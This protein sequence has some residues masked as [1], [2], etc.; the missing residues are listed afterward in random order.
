MLKPVLSVLAL[1]ASAAHAQPDF[2]KVVLTGDMLELRQETFTVG[3]VQSSWV[4][5]A[6]DVLA[7]LRFVNSENPVVTPE[8][9]EALVLF[10]AGGEP[11]MLLRRRDV[12]AGLPADAFV[13]ELVG[14]AAFGA[15]GSF[16]TVARLAGPTISRGTNDEALLYIEPDGRTTV[17]LNSGQ[18]VPGLPEG[19]RF[20]QNLPAPSLGA[21]GEVYFSAV[22]EN[23]DMLDDRPFLV[24]RRAPGGQVERQALMGSPVPGMP[25]GVVFASD[26]GSRV[27]NA[28]GD[29]LFYALFSG[30]EIPADDPVLGLFG[31]RDGATR[32]IYGFDEPIPG[33]DPSVS[34]TR[35]IETRINSQGRAAVIFATDA[36]R[37][38]PG[39]Y[40][41]DVV[42]A[43][44]ADGDLRPIART[45][46]PSPEFGSGARF[47]DFRSLSFNG[48]G[49]VAF[50]GRLFGSGTFEFF[51]DEVAYAERNGLLGLVARETD[52]AP[53]DPVNRGLARFEIAL[54]EEGRVLLPADLKVSPN[55]PNGEGIFFQNPGAGVETIAV[56]NQQILADPGGAF[57]TRTVAITRVRVPEGIN[58]SGLT[59]VVLDFFPPPQPGSSSGVYLVQ[60]PP[61][62]APL[63]CS[64]ADLAEPLG[65]ISQADSTE[66]VSLF[67]ADDPSAARLAEP[68]DSVTQ[69]DVAAFVSLFFEGCPSD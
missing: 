57:A 63:G 29:V 25:D 62:V 16:V 8:N 10:P 59:A 32:L 30:G 47:R 49:N 48:G 24:F 13:A 40:L 1:A 56:P 12:P 66:F 35:P 26:G 9:A 6:S 51:D 43:E 39:N 21:P 44:Q 2:S 53:N 50:A 23:P 27:A 46:E 69:L 65:L 28:G 20:D 22:A 36:P 38:V 54:D 34:V 33:F 5:D 45:D 31:A 42:L 17:L 3:D 68:F 15:N 64:P 61:V 7:Q 14:K 18:P 52:A 55:A 58:A 37:T 41:I 67:F 11:R 4:N 60:L 19:F